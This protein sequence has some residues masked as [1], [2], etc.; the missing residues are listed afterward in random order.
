MAKENGSS[1]LESDAT[2]PFQKAE[3]LWKSL[4][5]AESFDHFYVLHHEILPM[6]F[7][8][9]HVFQLLAHIVDERR[10]EFKER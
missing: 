9:L 4:Q 2:S 7:A 1:W 10:F 8:A 6:A 3:A 5:S